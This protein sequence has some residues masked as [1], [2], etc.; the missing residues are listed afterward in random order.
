[1]LPIQIL[2]NPLGSIRSSGNITLTKLLYINNDQNAA[3]SSMETSVSILQ[4]PQN[5]SSP[6]ASA[7]KL[8]IFQGRRSFRGIHWRSVKNKEAAQLLKG[9]KDFI[10]TRG[11]D[12]S[13]A[14]WIAQ[15]DP[16]GRITN[17]IPVIHER[18]G[19]WKEEQDKDGNDKRFYCFL[20]AG[21]GRASGSFG[22]RKAAEI[23]N[24]AGA[25][26]KKEQKKYTHNLWI[27]ELGRYVRCYWV[28][29]EKLAEF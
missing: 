14:D 17:P 23:L 18:A 9:V 12:F 4:I 24:D 2:L 26:C 11:A 13:N 1:M 20:A 8:R 19:Y 6:A 10:E 16:N 7:P 21:L 28:D 3:R 22:T 27:A 29:P 25:I 5:P 15:L